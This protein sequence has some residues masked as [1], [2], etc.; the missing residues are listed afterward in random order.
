MGYRE[1]ELV[2]RGAG[3]TPILLKS[4]QYGAHSAAG[5]TT[6]PAA[7]TGQNGSGAADTRVERSTPGKEL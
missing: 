7:S 4:Y 2:Q 5:T 6:Y 1:S 3:G